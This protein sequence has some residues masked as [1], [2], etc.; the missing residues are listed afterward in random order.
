[1]HCHFQ[2]N[3]IVLIAWGVVLTLRRRSFRHLFVLHYYFLPPAF[4]PSSRAL[5]EE[6][7]RARH[8]WASLESGGRLAFRFRRPSRGGRGGARGEF[9]ERRA[10]RR[11]ERDR[12]RASAGQSAL[13]KRPMTAHFQPKAGLVRRRLS[14]GAAASSSLIRP[15][16]SPPLGREASSGE[17]EPLSIAAY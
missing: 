8:L 2:L 17:A 10:A 16:T 12:E 7:G 13:R 1:M 3:Q 9:S 6:P 11:A 14:L 4:P 5:L 15:R